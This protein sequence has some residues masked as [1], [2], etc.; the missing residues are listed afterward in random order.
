MSI[1]LRSFITTALLVNVL[2]MGRA[3]AGSLQDGSTPPRRKPIVIVAEIVN[4]RIV[5]TVDSKPALPDILRALS[6]LREERGKDCP[7]VAMVDDRA[8]IK[9][10]ENIDGIAGK[11]GFPK[12]KFF[13]FD[14]EDGL[15]ASVEFGS[16]M[17]FSTNS[18][19]D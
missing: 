5:Y 11:A 1:S 14:K 7:V 12:V 10:M 4:H 6:I 13:V 8:P 9:E 16:D 18:P 17:P 19:V 2:T 15:M 3:T